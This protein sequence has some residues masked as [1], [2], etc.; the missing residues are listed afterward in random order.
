MEDIPLDT[1]LRTVF[2]HGETLP[3]FGCQVIA[4]LNQRYR[5][6]WI[7]HA[8]HYLVRIFRHN[9]A[10]LIFMECYERDFIQDRSIDRSGAFGL[11]YECSSFHTRKSQNDAMGNKLLFE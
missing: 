10:W 8:G 2:P 3:H 9:S 6:L 1:R 4:C 5:K 7:G 11:N